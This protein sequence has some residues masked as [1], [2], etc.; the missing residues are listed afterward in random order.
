[1]SSVFIEHDLRQRFGEA[2]DQGAR[3]TCL[4]FA[5]SDTHAAV[6]GGAWKP[7][8]AEYL[9]YHAVRRVGAGPGG[10]TAPSG[11]LETIEKDGQ[12]TET[13][14]PY[15]PSLPSDLTLWVPPLD[16]GEVFCCEGEVIGD[17]FDAVWNLIVTGRPAVIGM[18]LS[19]AFYLPRHGIV[20]ADEPVDTS[21]L[22]A[23]V[24]VAAG[25]RGSSRLVLV[26]NSWGVHWGTDGYAWLAH[27]YLSPRV[28]CALVLKEIA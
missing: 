22:H 17:S 25:R 2:R 18:S 24:A 26:R 7:L 19:D 12:P 21:R 9:Y 23:V 15:L 27:D 5:V 16:I 20:D 11:I 4:A 3:P 8:S 13:G 10:G 1:M 28:I 6:R 14:W